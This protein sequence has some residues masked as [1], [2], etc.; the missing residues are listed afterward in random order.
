MYVL[1]PVAV[2]R[3]QQEQAEDYRRHCT[4]KDWRHIDAF[5]GTNVSG[6]KAIANRKLRRKKLEDGGVLQHKKFFCHYD[7]NDFK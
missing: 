1:H 7:I 5:S 3:K 4:R 6:M 2:A